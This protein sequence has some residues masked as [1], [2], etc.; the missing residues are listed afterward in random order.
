[1]NTIIK[2]TNLEDYLTHNP[3][4]TFNKEVY[5]QYTE[6][7]NISKIYNFSTSDGF[8]YSYDDFCNTQVENSYINE[9]YLYM[10]EETGILSRTDIISVEILVKSNN[11]SSIYHEYSG[12]LLNAIKLATDYENINKYMVELPLVKYIFVNQFVQSKYKL[13][14]NVKVNRLNINL[15]ANVFY[16]KMLDK[17][18]ITDLQKMPIY[19]LVRHIV[20]ETFS[21]E[22][23]SNTITLSP[24]KMQC[25]LIFFIFPDNMNDVNAILK[26]G[27][28]RHEMNKY[29]SNRQFCGL[30]NNPNILIFDIYKNIQEFYNTQPTGN[31]LL[32]GN[33]SFTFDSNI[34]GY[35]TV[36]YVLLDLIMYENNKIKFFDMP[37]EFIDKQSSV[38]YI[39]IVS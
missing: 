8:I 33:V 9:I 16:T 25:C 28:N 15:F 24:E 39:K 27:D 12:K 20:S 5:R 32:D 29:T 26:I 23:G 1:M 31:V 11:T 35:L 17:K 3:A 18:E 7:M 22:K 13:Q 6:V 30:C 2:T 34:L 37:F 38:K 10:T 19:R 21:I 14:I 36:G 4:I